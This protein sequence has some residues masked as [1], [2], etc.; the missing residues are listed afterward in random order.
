MKFITLSGRRWNRMAVAK[1]PAAKTAAPKKPA[2]KKA[3]GKKK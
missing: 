1:K 3:A 2:A